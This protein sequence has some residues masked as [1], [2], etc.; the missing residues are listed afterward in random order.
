MLEENNPFRD[1][2]VQSQVEQVQ[3]EFLQLLTPLIEAS[4]MEIFDK[5]IRTALNRVFTTAFH[6]RARCVAPRGTRYEL[7]Q[8]KAGGVFD[9]EYMEAQR[10]DG[11][12]IQS[13]PSSRGKVRRVK[14]CIH[15][16]LVSHVI[17]DEPSSYDGGESCSTISQQFVSVY[18]NDQT[19]EKKLRGALKS[20]KAI[21]ILEDDTQP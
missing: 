21:V 10:P 2:W 12:I 11:C 16:C 13:V 5:D 18:E 4:K 19:V 6:F 20:G 9:P 8:V 15:G 3:S 1:C 7:M 17:E 14:V